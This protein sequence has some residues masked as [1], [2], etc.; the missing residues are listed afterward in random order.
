MP[1]SDG[2]L[3][4]LS[5]DPTGSIRNS[6]N[7]LIKTPLPASKAKS[8]LGYPTNQQS[9]GRRPFLREKKISHLHEQAKLSGSQ[10]FKDRFGSKIMINDY[11]ICASQ[12]MPSFMPFVV[13]SL[14]RALS[15]AFFIFLMICLLFRLKKIIFVPYPISATNTATHPPH[16]PAIT[17]PPRTR[18]CTALPRPGPRIRPLRW[19]LQILLSVSE[20]PAFIFFY[21]L[22][23]HEKDAYPS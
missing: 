3:F 13:P 2:R 20:S 11:S 7:I 6:S 5:E 12:D 9:K 19:A 8:L 10:G 14:G 16:L 17:P 1:H 23:S 21:I 18:Q 22:Y 15:N 4:S